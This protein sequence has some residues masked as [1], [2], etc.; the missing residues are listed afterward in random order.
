MHDS[1]DS[2]AHCISHRTLRSD[3]LTSLCSTGR[4]VSFLKWEIP[5]EQMI[6]KTLRNP[7]LVSDVGLYPLFA[8]TRQC[9]PCRTP[10]K[11]SVFGV[12]CS[13]EDI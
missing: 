13:V 6:G 7:L 10:G 11:F 3:T 9:E 5:E 12:Q 2:D 4:D 1:A 8:P